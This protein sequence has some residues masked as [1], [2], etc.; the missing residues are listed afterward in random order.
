M[1]S[2]DLVQ[3]LLPE[4]YTHCEF[5]ANGSSGRVDLIKCDNRKY[6]AKTI[7][8]AHFHEMEAKVTELPDFLHPN[9]ARGISHTY[10]SDSNY[11]QIL[12]EYYSEGELFGKCE[13]FSLDQTISAIGQIAKAL[14]FC[15]SKGIVHADV[16]TENILI[17]G[18]SPFHVRLADFGLSFELPYMF[19]GRRGTSE[20]MS[21]EMISHE[22]K[23]ISFPTDMW[24]FGVCVYEMLYDSVP[25]GERGE[26]LESMENLK[27][28]ICA[29]DF[30]YPDDVPKIP[31]AEDFI[32][33]LLVVDPQKRMT[34]QQC[35]E[36]PL[37]SAWYQHDLIKDMIQDIVNQ[38]CSLE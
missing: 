10:N 23:K 35:L 32:S 28:N 15:H 33:R 4:G 38:S 12:F 36:H 1:A 37:L 16:K 14:A 24:S 3:S 18:M 34:A 25:F 8:D 6:A 26:R 19:I 20:F 29:V 11:H 17:D 5:I 13:K 27:K 7:H 9:I 22:Y 21:P 31:D 30:S 2:K